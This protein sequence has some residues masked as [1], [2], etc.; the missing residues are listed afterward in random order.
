MGDA[1]DARHGHFVA[2]ANGLYLF[3]VTIMKPSSGVNLHVEMVKN[4]MEIGKL[5]N[6]ESAYNQASITAFVQL[7]TGDMVWARHMSGSP[8][9]V[10]T[11]RH[12]S[13]F[14]G[15]LISKL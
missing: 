12:Y 14:G 11:G 4:G 15:A 7:N 9:E 3:T 2:P 6:D 5:H 1:Y 8:T 13:S 10:M